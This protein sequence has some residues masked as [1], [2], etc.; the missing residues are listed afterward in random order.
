[1]A[2]VFHFPYRT[3]AEI[4]LR[5]L[6]RNLHT[7][8]SISQKEVIPVIKANAYGH[9]MVPVAKCLAN[10][11]SC[12]MVAVATLE[13]GIEVRQAVP[14]G[15]GILVLSGFFPH[16]LEAFLKFR[17]TPVIHNLAHL[18]SLQGHTELPDL[19]LKV[20]SGMNRLGIST[21]QIDEAIRILSKLPV[22][23]SGLC[24][25]FADSDDLD[26]VFIDQQTAVF[27]GVFERLVNLRLLHT[28]ARIHLSNSGA[29]L[30]QKAGIATAVRL[31]ISLF[32]IPPNDRLPH[33]K[34]LLPVLEWKTRVLC[35]KEISKG[36]TVGYG[37]TYKANRKEKNSDF[38]RRVCRWVCAIVEQ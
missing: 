13:E 26:S 11:G 4:S 31:G 23:L 24:T 14:R 12:S 6:L 36:D 25:Q 2:T 22:K 27:E 17:L 7:L 33:S 5:A 16:Q 37:R 29:V 35:L 34:S 28:D 30:R 20:D 38:A 21:K 1:M 10:R 19:H 8:R 32:G 15:L 3:V 18:K 9:G